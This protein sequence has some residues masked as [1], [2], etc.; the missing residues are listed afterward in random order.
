MSVYRADHIIGPNTLANVLAA[1]ETFLE[2]LDS[3]DNPLQLMELVKEGD[4]RFRLTIL[5]DYPT[6]TTTTTTTTT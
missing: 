3:T 4:N 1:A 2:T 5:Y 6:S